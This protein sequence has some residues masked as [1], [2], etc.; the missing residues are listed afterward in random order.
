MKG[1]WFFVAYTYANDPETL[2]ENGGPSQGP[3]PNGRNI[4]LITKELKGFVRIQ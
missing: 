2:Q 1:F 4:Y 3:E